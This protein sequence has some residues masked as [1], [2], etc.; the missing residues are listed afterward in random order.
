MDAAANGFKAARLYRLGGM[1]LVI[2]AVLQVT[3]FALHPAGEQLSH[4]DQPLYGPAHV[5]MFVSWVLVMAGLPAVYARIADRAGTLGVVAFLSSLV[6]IA[7]HCYLTL[8][9]GFAVGVMA[10]NEGARSLLGPDGPLAHGAGALGIVAMASLLAFPLLGI[11][12]LR[13]GSFPRTSG[14][15]LVAALPGFAVGMIAAGMFGGP[16]GPEADNWFSGMLPVTT[17]Y[18]LAFAGYAVAGNRLRAEA[19]TGTRA[20]ASGRA[21][22]V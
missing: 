8:Y 15:L 11:A 10:A 5:V 19:S 13:S 1:A 9:E 21:V 2:A 7:Y 14:W 16:I 17:L 22:S 6:A 18:T 4:V 12:I 3:G 20:V